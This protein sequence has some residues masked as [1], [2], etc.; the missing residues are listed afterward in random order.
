M[1]IK[2]LRD[3]IKYWK[4]HK[5]VVRQCGLI[6][7]YYL[8]KGEETVSRDR[9]Q[10]ET[11]FVDAFSK[12]DSLESHSVESVP[13]ATGYPGEA[14]YDYDWDSFANFSPEWKEN[15]P[16]GLEPPFQFEAR[17]DS[18]DDGPE[19]DILQAIGRGLGYPD[20]A[21]VLAAIN[22]YRKEPENGR[23]P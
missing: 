4:Q 3:T 20:A 12:P 17:Q 19:V 14:I 7:E 23:R 5:S 2:G 13:D 18:A 10:E 1:D 15:F 6:V 16:F 21:I 8:D 22:R 9:C 11:R